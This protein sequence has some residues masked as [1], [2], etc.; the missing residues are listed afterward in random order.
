MDNSHERVRDRNR[1]TA[2][3]KS[4]EESKMAPLSCTVDRVRDRNRS[5]AVDKSLEESI[6]L[7]RYYAPL[8]EFEIITDQAQSTSLSKESLEES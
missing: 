6:K 2:V 1:S 8:I 3:D 4:L 7:H 5:T